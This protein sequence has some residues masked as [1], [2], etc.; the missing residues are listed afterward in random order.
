MIASLG[1]GLLFLEPG[2]VSSKNSL[3]KD[4]SRSPHRGLAVL[5]QAATQKPGTLPVFSARIHRQF[6]P[7]CQGTSW[8]KTHRAFFGWQ[9]FQNSVFQPELE[10]QQLRPHR[11][12]RN[13]SRNFFSSSRHARDDQ[14]GRSTGRLPECAERCGV[15]SGQ[16]M[17]KQFAHGDRVPQRL[18]RNSFA[19]H[20]PRQI[21]VPFIRGPRQPIAFRNFPSPLQPQQSKR[22]TRQLSKSHFPFHRAAKIRNSP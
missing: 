16:S 20:L 17:E 22:P 15:D 11:R 6:F 18:L 1:A 12:R 5:H 2:R 4:G 8:S 21:P 9:R 10:A 19:A 13:I 14:L 7:D 3:K